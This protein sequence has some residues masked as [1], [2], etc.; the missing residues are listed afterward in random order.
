[1]VDLLGAIDLTDVVCL[2]NHHLGWLHVAFAHSCYRCFSSDCVRGFNGN[3]GWRGEV[4]VD[5][6]TDSGG[7]QVVKQSERRLLL[8][9]E[10]GKASF[11]Q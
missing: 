7:T 6:A 4:G 3:I 11:D 2:C 1:M 10:N 9:D 5:G 8:A